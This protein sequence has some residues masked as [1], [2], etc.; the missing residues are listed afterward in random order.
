MNS[1]EKLSL[2][3]NVLK[4]RSSTTS[5]GELIEILGPG[6]AERSVRRWLETLVSQGY[7]IKTGRMR[8][9]RYQLAR[10]QV[11]DNLLSE[12]ALAELQRVRQ[13]LFKRDPVS[14][15]DEWIRGYQPNITFYLSEE[16]R[17]V[18]SAKGRRRS[19]DEL[20]GTYARK[21]YN[22]LLIDLTYNSSRLE[23]NTYS[24]L[25]TQRLVLDG[26]PADGKLDLEKVMILNHKEAIR[27]MIDDAAKLEINL[28]EICT[29][30][31]LLADGLVERKYAGKIR[32]HGVR[33]VGSTYFP[34]EDHF[35]LEQQLSKLCALA[36]AIIDPFEQSFFLLI[37][38]AYLQAFIDVNKR[39]ARIS[40][41]IPLIK[42]N[43]APLSFADIEMDDYN[44]AMI[45]IYEQNQ[46]LPLAELYYYS[47]LRSCQQYDAALTAIGFDRIRVQYRQQR[48]DII[49]QVISNGMVGLAMREFIK[50]KANETVA[51]NDQT[52]FIDVIMSDLND[53]SLPRI[54]GMAITRTEL[55]AWLKLK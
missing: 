15:N 48:R 5:I 16:M 34:Y 14:Y 10:A 54:V 42:N 6:F 47:Y 35:R 24:L 52:A 50:Q 7:V 27:H 2:I 18:L 40:A 3:L 11:L 20:A 8:S 39:T 33:V 23:G 46:I 55:E 43:F 37:H 29:I 1:E 30:H 28:N 17:R 12:K 45:C 21:I 38:V 26:A 31:Y 53:I 13:P 4:Q 51:E 9:T 36:A 25:E 19:D 32:D 22:R 41:N 44:S 49:Q